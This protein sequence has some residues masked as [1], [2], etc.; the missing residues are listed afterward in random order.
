MDTSYFTISDRKKWRKKAENYLVLNINSNGEQFFDE[1][2]AQAQ[3][4]LKNGV[5]TLYYV[6]ISKGHDNDLKYYQRLINAGIPED[7][8]QLLDR[9]SD[10][11]YFLSMLANAKKVI[12][13]RL[14]LFLVSSFLGVPVQTFPYQK[15]ILKM[16]KVLQHYDIS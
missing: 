1:I 2:L 5:D 6:P 15:K 12:G 14:H 9:E 10:F 11:K 3:L 4:A 16:Q 7:K 13:T 8:L